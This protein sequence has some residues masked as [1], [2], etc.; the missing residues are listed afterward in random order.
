MASISSRT[1]MSTL[2]GGRSGAEGLRSVT[3][4]PCSL[5]MLGVAFQNLA[6]FDVGLHLAAACAQHPKG[7]VWQANAAT[8]V[9]PRIR[10]SLPDFVLSTCKQQRQTSGDQP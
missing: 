9:T 8:L 1:S 10:C 5:Q 3:G 6:P 4:A 2:E 7:A